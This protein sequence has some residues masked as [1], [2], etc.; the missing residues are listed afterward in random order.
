MPLAEAGR[1]QADGLTVLRELLDLPLTDAWLEPVDEALRHSFWVY[2]R[3]T[4]WIVKH[5]ELHPVP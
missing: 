1:R 3:L 5:Q 4:H 2:P